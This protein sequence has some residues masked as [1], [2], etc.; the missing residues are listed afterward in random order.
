MA[1]PRTIPDE[2][3]IKPIE[4]AMAT[5][6]YR[7]IEVI[8]TAPGGG[9]VEIAHYPTDQRH[10]FDVPTSVARLVTERYLHA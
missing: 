5:G 10:V 2:D 1:K 4:A 9:R 3:Y 6:E 8:I 7:L